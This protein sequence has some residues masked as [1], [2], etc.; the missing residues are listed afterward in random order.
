MKEEELSF[1]FWLKEDGSDQ[2]LSLLSEGQKGSTKWPMHCRYTP[3]RQI[4]LRLKCCLEL[5]LAFNQLQGRFF[6]TFPEM[7]KSKT[8]TLEFVGVFFCW[9]VFS[10]IL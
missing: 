10:N 8:L 3:N 2:N 9:F 6:D 7:T 1:E 5:C 4:V